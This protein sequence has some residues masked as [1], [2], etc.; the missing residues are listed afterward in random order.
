MEQEIFVAI[1]KTQRPCAFFGG[2]IPKK[3]FQPPTTTTKLVIITT[4]TAHTPLFVLNTLLIPV[5]DCV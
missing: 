1:K 2:I 5:L 4:N 3:R